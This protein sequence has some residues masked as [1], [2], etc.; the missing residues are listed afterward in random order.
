M[1]CIGRSIDFHL[2]RIKLEDSA[3]K[4]EKRVLNGGEEL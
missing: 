3:E 2:E 4:M 1:R